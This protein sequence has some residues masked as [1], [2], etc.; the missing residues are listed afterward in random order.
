MTDNKITSI[1]NDISNIVS[2]PID[3]E[4]LLISLNKKLVIDNKITKEDYDSSN[5]S[6]SHN[7]EE[8]LSF[9][10]TVNSDLF[11]ISIDGIPKFY[12]KDEKS[13][14]EKMWSIS[15][16]FSHEKFLCGYN[17]NYVKISSTELHIIGSYRLFLMA[18][19][20][21][22]HRIKYSRIKEC[23]N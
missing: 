7:E 12:V 4:K 6:D 14:R 11:V 2:N 19:E 15:R 21:T 17:T 13:A 18:Y 5:T 3:D 10:F 9:N 16:S 23:V 20:Q 1:E 8:E 22:L